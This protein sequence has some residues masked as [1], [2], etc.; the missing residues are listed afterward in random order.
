MSSSVIYYFLLLLLSLLLLLIV[1]ISSSGDKLGHKDGVWYNFHV[2]HGADSRGKQGDHDHYS[3]EIDLPFKNLF[4]RWTTTTTTT[5]ERTFFGKS[6]AH[7]VIG[8]SFLE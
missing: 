3:P 8:T 2:D 6:L 4:I 7:I 5:T 1:L